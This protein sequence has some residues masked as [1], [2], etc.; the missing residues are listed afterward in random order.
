MMVRFSFYQKSEIWL[1][2]LLSLAKRNTN[3]KFWVSNLI[4]NE[5][6]W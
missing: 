5:T 4:L 6:S 2:V 3:S 1:L